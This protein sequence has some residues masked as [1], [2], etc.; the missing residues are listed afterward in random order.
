[1]TPRRTDETD[2][3]YLG[4]L[5]AHAE[6]EAKKFRFLLSVMP[7]LRELPAVNDSALTRQCGEWC[8]MSYI[9]AINAVREFVNSDWEPTEISKEL[10]QWLEL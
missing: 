5:T 10:C 3:E 8:Q 6:H 4:R 9:A 2:R 7:L 1:M